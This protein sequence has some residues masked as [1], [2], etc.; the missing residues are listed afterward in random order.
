[1]TDVT[2]IGEVLS[3]T[4]QDEEKKATIEFDPDTTDPIVTLKLTNKNDTAF[5]AM[6]TLC[7][8]AIQF[9]STSPP[10]NHVHSVR[11]DS[12]SKEIK[13]IRYHRSG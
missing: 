10:F 12:G 3:L 6:V 7:T 4:V 11:Y 5:N 9:G 2:A 8:L 13:E 1:M